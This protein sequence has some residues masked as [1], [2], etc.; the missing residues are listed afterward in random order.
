MDN[1]ASD[2]KLDYESDVDLNISDDEDDCL[3][4][5]GLDL[6]FSRSR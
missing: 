1:Q 2:T 4:F 3:G 6:G 5:L